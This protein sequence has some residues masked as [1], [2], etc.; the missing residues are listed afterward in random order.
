MA[1]KRQPTRPLHGCAHYEYIVCN[2]PS[3]EFPG[4][5]SQLCA[6]SDQPPDSAH[7][8]R[9]QT[10]CAQLQEHS[11]VGGSGP[12]LPAPSRQVGLLAAQ[13]STLLGSVSHESE[14]GCALQQPCINK[15]IAYFQQT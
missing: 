15:R 11:S 1:W 4:D 14:A 7:R 13:R 8:Q 2:C 9:W 5:L 10:C 6:P 3:S 12:W